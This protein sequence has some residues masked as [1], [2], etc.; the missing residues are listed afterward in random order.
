MKTKEVEL[1]DAMIERGDELDNAAYQYF[2]TL[3]EL[4]GAEHEKIEEIFPWDISILRDLLYHATALLNRKNLFICNPCIMEAYGKQYLCLPSEC[5]CKECHCQ[6]HFME[7]ERILARITEAMELNGLEVT[8]STEDALSVRE[9]NT[10]S[11]FQIQI[12]PFAP[13]RNIA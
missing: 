12:N 8:E 9:R 5:G 10:G 6:D 3:L 1:N 7:K 2:L 13:E 4:N 11:H